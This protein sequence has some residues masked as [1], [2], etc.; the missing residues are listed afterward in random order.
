MPF[1]EAQKTIYSDL[2]DQ[3]V[4]RDVIHA[5]LKQFKDDHKE[6]IKLSGGK[7]ELIQNLLDAVDAGII[8]I[9]SVQ[10]LI[11]DAEE[12][13]DQ[14]VFS[15]TLI[16]ASRRSFYNDGQRLK[17]IIVPLA[18][19]NVF[20]RL[21]KMPTQL[22][23][24]DFRSPNRGVNNSWMLKLYDV[25]YRYTKEGDDFDPLTNR[26]TIVYKRSP[27]RLIYIVEWDGNSILEIKVSRSLYDSNKSVSDAVGEISRL[28]YAQGAGI[29][30]HGDFSK[31]D[32]TDCV[33][34]FVTRQPLNPGMYTIHSS[35]LMDPTG[36]VGYIR[37]ADDNIGSDVL[38]EDSSAGAIQ[39]YIDNNSK[40]VTTYLKFLSNGSH[41]TLSSD[42]NVHV[43]RDDINHIILIASIKP[44][45]YRYVRRKIEEF[46]I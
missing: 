16:N 39:S 36:G 38:A 2:L 42:I 13:G 26:R 25:K 20:P 40:G 11:K 29:L 10:A 14:H 35:T 43:G 19:R 31:T 41:D 12:F 1:T 8:N 46:S 28:I 45:D 33:T 3:Y 30:L 9:F 23:W 22:E 5:L 32:F 24:A 6:A 17:D 4:V 44:Q 21:F 7:P 27:S 18:Y 34:S 15:F 37:A